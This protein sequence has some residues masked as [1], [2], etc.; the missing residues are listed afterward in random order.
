MQVL[1][2]KEAQANQVYPLINWSDLFPGFK[3]FQ[4]EMRT[5]K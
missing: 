3:R 1:F 2:D 4:E 5:R